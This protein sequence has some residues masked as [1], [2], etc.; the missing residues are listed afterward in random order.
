MQRFLPLIVIA[1]FLVAGCAS[2]GDDDDATDRET[3]PASNQVADGCLPGTMST[4]AYSTAADDDTADCEA[5]LLLEWNGEKL[6][7]EHRCA[8]RNCGLEF[9]ADYLAD[10]A[11]LTIYER[12]EAE[13]M[14]MCNCLYHLSYEVAP[15]PGDYHLILYEENGAG[16]L[17][18]RY[19]ENIS[20]PAGETRSYSF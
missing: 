19:D 9:A 6:A 2:S 18:L 11:T 3:L 15:A 20:L 5:Q 1:L 10:D 14:T 17:S 4:Q 7:V 16:Y 13:L 8:Y 12:D